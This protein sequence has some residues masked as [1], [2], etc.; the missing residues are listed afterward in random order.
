MRRP[1][2]LVA[3]GQPEDTA[4]MLSWQPGA[5]TCYFDDLVANGIFNY[6]AASPG[7]SINVRFRHPSDWQRHPAGSA[8][9]FGE[10][11]ANQW[12]TLKPLDPY[13]YFASRLNTHYANGDPNPANQRHYIT[14]EFYQRCARWI[15]RTADVIKQAV[16]EMKLVSPPFAFGF[17]EDGSPDDQGR[18]LKGWAG[19]DYLHETVRDYFDGILTFQAYWGYPAAGSVPD[20]LYEPTLSS[21]YAFRWQRLLQLFQ[22]RYAFEAKVIIDEAGSFGPA[23]PDFTS[24]LIYYAQQCLSDDRVISLS[25]ALWAN[26]AGDPLYA[27][28][29]WVDHVPHLEQHL[30]RLKGMPDLPLAGGVSGADQPAALNPPPPPVA[31]VAN[32]PADQDLFNDPFAGSLEGILEVPFTLEQG[33]EFQPAPQAGTERPIRVL[34]EDGRVET[35]PLEEY[36]RAVVPAEMPAGWPLEALKAQAVASRTYAQYAIEHP[37]FPNADI[38]TTAKCQGYDPT[39]IRERSDQAVRQTEGLILRSNGQTINALFSA[40]CGGQTRNNEEVWS[41]QALPYLRGVSCPNTDRRSGHG[42]GLCQYGARELARQGKS[43]DVILR[44]YYQS[45]TL[46]QI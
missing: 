44:H 26:P 28:H 34:F 12:A 38:C 35:M 36:L 39:R 15:G 31:T 8:K 25:Y 14:P 21:W 17:N 43:Y 23:D 32:P 33:E 46:E 27:P 45:V 2:L 37:R 29:A 13:V 6:K 9:A 19:F 7:V 20:W 1:G 11:I 42:V 3:N 30:D 5:I 4:Q 18:P 10:F 22:A 24:Q 40:N 41:G 16:P